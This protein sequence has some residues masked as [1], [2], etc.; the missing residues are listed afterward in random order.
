MI[1]G[2]KF[3]LIEMFYMFFW[4]IVIVEYKIVRFI[5]LNL[6]FLYVVIIIYFKRIEIKRLN[7]FFNMN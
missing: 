1:V 6:S 2:R 5:I 4:M 7:K 3:W